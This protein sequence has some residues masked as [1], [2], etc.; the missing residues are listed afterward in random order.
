M[1]MHFMKADEAQQAVIRGEWQKA[2]EP[3]L[4]L[5]EHEDA[6]HSTPTWSPYVAA[7]R[8]A[9]AEAAN[10]QDITAAATGIARVAATCGACHAGLGAGPTFKI[11][12]APA[13]SEEM[14]SH[15]KRHQWAA[16]RLWEGMVQPSDEAWSAGAAALHD[17]SLT[18]TSDEPEMA[19]NRQV[20][21]DHVHNAAG[22]P[23]ATNDD[24]VAVYAHILSTCSACHLGTGGGPKQGGGGH[25][26]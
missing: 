6:V 19:K 16:A 20:L 24:K 3:M 5:A 9:A 11:G 21:A 4:W 17:A 1:K 2:R 7:M 15:M 22:R 13:E 8:E 23:A 12:E 26:P 10:A 25:T 18:Q 14:K